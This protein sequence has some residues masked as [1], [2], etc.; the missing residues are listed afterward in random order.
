MPAATILQIIPTLETGG[1]E[2]STIEIAEAVVKSGGRALVLSEGGRLSSW[3]ASVGGELITFPAATKNPARILWN[4]KSISDIAR[5]EGV[6]LI[7]ARS[8]APAWSALIAART[9]SVPFVT[10]YHG[11]YSE[12]SRI[13][14]L[15]NSGMARSNIIIANSRYTADLVKSR[16]GIGDDRVRVIYRGVDVDGYAAQNIDAGRIAALKA[17]WGVT[18]AH[19]VVLHA[20][21]LTAWKGQ[22]DIIATAARLRNRFNDVVFILAGDAQGRSG[23]LADLQRQIADLGVQDIVRLVGHV[24]DMPAAFA[25]AAVA[26]VA[27]IEPEAFGRA[28]AE[29]QAAGCPVI[30][31][32]IGAPP[33]TVLAPPR[34]EP[35]A[36]TGWLVPPG[37]LDAYERVLAE[38]LTLP[39]NRLDEVSRNAEA[40]IRASFTKENMQRQT[41]DVYDRLLG[42]SLLDKFSS[43]SA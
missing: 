41:L 23:Y 20:A 15:Y 1:A 16:Y 35:A 31:T 28:A 27:S 33:E 6:H 9:C 2:L 32:D 11:A 26:F 8:R 30:S 12:K 4:A 39:A 42:T 22:S 38:V 29:A 5:R 13:K 43:K 37:D 3:L 25:A 18:D 24:D 7:H 10:T 40:H 34:V 14:N 19:R 36:R 21:R 17:K